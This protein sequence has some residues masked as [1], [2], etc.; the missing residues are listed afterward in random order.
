MRGFVF[1]VLAIGL[2]A[3][4]AK[5]PV[6]PTAPPAPQTLD[7]WPFKPQSV[8]LTCE[9]NNAGGKAVFVTTPDGT[10]YAVNGTA[11]ARAP[12]MDPINSDYRVDA[13]I[14]AGL[15]L[16]DGGGGSAEF[17]APPKV[18]ETVPTAETPT[19]VARV[20][21][22]SGPVGTFVT[23]KSDGGEA[24][25]SL[26]CRGGEPTGFQVAFGSVPPT[27]PPLRGTMATVETDGAKR[28]LEMGWGM[29]DRW[30]PRR[31]MDAEKAKARA[32][33]SA[34][35]NAKEIAVYGPSG[36]TPSLPRTWRLGDEMATVRKACAG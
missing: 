12:A 16:C 5:A 32:A 6:P 8:T 11:R 34:I 4:E 1:G 17:V 19:T 31:D 29:K 13:A 23:M 24:V 7:P 26:E 10:R 27:P 2:V 14:Q 36:F 21:V 22:D 35:L 20:S 9:T 33:A 3:C 15:A 30:F 25:L 18:A 28:V